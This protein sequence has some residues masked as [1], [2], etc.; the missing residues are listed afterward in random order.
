MTFETW[1]K[2]LLCK[3]LKEQGTTIYVRKPKH[4][5]G[6][7]CATPY[8]FLLHVEAE[9][10]HVGY[11]RIKYEIMPLIGRLFD[12]IDAVPVAPRVSMGYS[13]DVATDYI[14]KFDYSIDHDCLSLKTHS[15]G[16]SATD[17]TVVDMIR[18]FLNP[19][20]DSLTSY[21]NYCKGAIEMPFYNEVKDVNK[22]KE[23]AQML[24]DCGLAA[25]ISRPV[26]YRDNFP[27]D[28]PWYTLRINQMPYVYA[29]L[30]KY[31]EALAGIHG[32]REVRLRSAEFT[33][34][35]GCWTKDVYLEEV[36]LI[37][38]RCR[39]IEESMQKKD[40][41][42]IRNILEANYQRNRELIYKLL[43]LEIPETCSALQNR[44]E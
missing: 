16:E 34:E 42:R 43:G 39:E 14:R 8:G 7:Y 29:L 30:G 40:I 21:E 11:F 27:M 44:T 6:W 4:L 23:L 35:E 20:F 15:I 32:L 12:P 31:E 38:N 10:I 28:Y 1:A 3:E 5:Q 17:E 33:Y 13:T 25:G 22:R 26:Y 37:E 2:E 9:K 41:V 18:N 24:F 19:L 36:N